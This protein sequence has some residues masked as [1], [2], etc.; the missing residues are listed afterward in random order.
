MSVETW[1]KEFYPEK[2][3]SQSLLVLAKRCL[4][5]WEGIKKQNLKKQIWIIYHRG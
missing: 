4:K 1:K 2:S 5:K 3:K